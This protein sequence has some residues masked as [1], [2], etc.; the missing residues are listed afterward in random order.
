MTE[1]SPQGYQGYEKAA[2]SVLEN[3]IEHFNLKCVEHQVWIP[4][5]S[6]TGWKADIKGVKKDG[7][8]FVFIECRRRKRIDQAQIA[9]LAYKIRD[10]G[11][12]GG[13]LVASA[14]LQ[15]GAKK[16]AAHEKIKTVF[17]DRESTKSEYVMQLYEQYICTREHSAV[18]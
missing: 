8:G 17:L 12:D 16:V 7:Q 15:K 1:Q 14:A 4:G 9:E 10:T 11:A 5:K 13:I 6:G 2:L 3:H 18:A